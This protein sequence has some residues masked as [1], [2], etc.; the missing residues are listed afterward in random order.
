MMGPYY[1]YDTTYAEDSASA[2]IH[3]HDC[4]WSGECYSC[5][6][7]RLTFSSS[8]LAQNGGT[9]PITAGGSG[10]ITLTPNL[11]DTPTKRQTIWQE[12]KSATKLEPLTDTAS[13][14]SPPRESSPIE[15]SID[16]KLDQQHPSVLTKGPKKPSRLGLKKSHGIKKSFSSSDNKKLRHREVEKNRHRQLQAMV[17]TLSDKIPGKLDKETQ[18]QTMK[19]AARYCLYLRDVMNSYSN[20]QVAVT[21]EKLEKIYSR[22]CDNVELIMS[23]QGS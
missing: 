13:L 20:G 14:T 21:R 22:S 1:Y 7:A 19:R 17:K 16:I 10:Y 15:K 6:P 8:T 3:I 4:M 11:T 18:V 9:V 2:D 12:P 5:H 23:Q